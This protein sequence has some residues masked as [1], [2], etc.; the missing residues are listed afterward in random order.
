[1]TGQEFVE[2]T[3]GKIRSRIEHVEGTLQR[4]L[5]STEKM[6]YR[7]AYMFGKADGL[8]EANKIFA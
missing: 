2:T 6:L 4:C 7:S 1:M 5:S 8:R 3:E